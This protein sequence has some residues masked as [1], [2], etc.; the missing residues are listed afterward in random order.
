MWPLGALLFEQRV[1]RR[2][3]NGSGCVIPVPQDGLD[4]FGREQRK[5]LD[6]RFG[7]LDSGA[8][9][10]KKVIQEKPRER[11]GEEIGIIL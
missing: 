7:L 5:L 9:D 4:L 8:G 2:F 3:G 1:D 11:F 6:F 10:L